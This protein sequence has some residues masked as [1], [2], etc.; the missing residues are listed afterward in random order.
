MCTR[1]SIAFLRS[2]PSNIPQCYSCNSERSPWLLAEPQMNREISPEK[3][4]ITTDMI[5]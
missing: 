3:V 2:F 1:F 5:A 4:L